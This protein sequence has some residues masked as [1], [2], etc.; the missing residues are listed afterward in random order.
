MGAAFFQ[1]HF[2]LFHEQ[3]LAPTLDSEAVQNLVALVSHAQQFHRVACAQ[4]CLHALPATAQ[5]AFAEVAMTMER[6]DWTGLK[7]VTC[8]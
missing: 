5:A 8:L 1:R 4:K 6:G 3:P 2:Q 7:F